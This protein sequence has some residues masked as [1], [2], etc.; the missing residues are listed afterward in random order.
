MEARRLDGMLNAIVKQYWHETAA[1]GGL[2]R[3]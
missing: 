2:I 1:L 3:C